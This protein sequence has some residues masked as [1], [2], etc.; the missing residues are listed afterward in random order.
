[1]ERRKDNKGR[2]LK[3]GESQRKD[4]L[5]QYRWTDVY[6]KRQTIYASELKQL[7]EKENEVLKSKALSLNYASGNITVL[8]LAKQYQEIKL[9][10]IRRKTAYN[11]SLYVKRFASY[12]IGSK[13]IKDVTILDAK[14]WAKTLYEEFGKTYNT[15]DREK[16][17]IQGAFNLA[18]EDRRLLENP[19][20]F[21]LSSV[22][23]SNQKHRKALTDEE[24]EK[25]IRFVEN[26]KPYKKHLD[27]II[28]IHE[29]GVRI[30]E[31]CGLTLSDVDFD[32]NCI[33]INKQLVGS[34]NQG[35]YIEKPKTKA[36]N[37]TIPLTPD[38][39]KSLENIIASRPHLDV[40]PVIDNVSGFLFINRNGH[41]RPPWDYSSIF[42][43]LRGRYAKV[44]KEPAPNITPHVL[45]HTFCTNM[46]KMGINIKEL[47]YLMGHSCCSVTLDVYSHAS[48]SEIGQK[49]KIMQSSSPGNYTKHYT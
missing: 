3:E 38:A 48:V 41:P 11:N 20:A 25:I 28:L 42:E 36:G 33:Y 16:A 37:R 17:F 40:E 7:R 27:A 29:T 39:R 45:R 47:Q 35:T 9:H 5:Y 49:F 19:F 23:P 31:M 13:R 12:E 26:S 21:K 43:N 34:N 18:V 44:M 2:V 32:K 15:I 8:E 24:Y 46:I 6:G 4:G 30:G 10:V 1:M 22:V 14:M